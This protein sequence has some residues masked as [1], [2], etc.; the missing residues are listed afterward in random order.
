MRSRTLILALLL[1]ACTA[2][3]TPRPDAPRAA[4]DDGPAPAP[5]LPAS[6]G[7]VAT[8]TIGGGND[9]LHAASRT[10]TWI[11]VCRGEAG[12]LIA[13]ESYSLGFDAW[14]GADDIGR[15]VLVYAG[16][17]P[18]LVDVWTHTA[19]DLP[20][21]GHT[22]SADGRR[23]AYKKDRHTA[24]VR[25][26]ATGAERRFTA[27]EPLSYLVLDPAAAF[28]YMHTFV[29]VQERPDDDAPYV[30][31]STC[32]RPRGE[33]VEG[34]MGRPSATIVALDE[35]GAPQLPLPPRHAPEHATF[36]GRPLVRDDVTGSTLVW[37]ETNLVPLGGD[38]R[39][40]LAAAAR[41]DGLAYVAT[42]DGTPTLMS[43]L[44]G[45][46]R[47]V[48]PAEQ[49]TRNNPAPDSHLTDGQNGVAQATERR[50]L[51]LGT[52]RL[53]TAGPD[54]RHAYADADRMLLIGDAYTIVDP[55]TGATLHRHALSADPGLASGRWI[56]LH[57][58]GETTVLDLDNPA[59]VGHAPGTALALATTGHVLISVAPSSTYTHS[60]QKPYGPYR[61]HAP[62]P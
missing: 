24:V 18:Q 44:A 41:A 29:P 60:K 39:R 43:V 9:T 33:S 49:D 59:W 8:G 14:I 22:L 62:A 47:P 28:L 13:D 54:V 4:P 56:A 58:R 21:T 20:G 6:A 34:R 19:V 7:V 55:D 10:A 45:E 17:R 31:D 38:T 11:A 52:G 15:N 37:H 50:W 1:G 27:R 3:G 25:E 40:S 61:W 26:L 35:P 5:Q 57:G 2:D 53:V 16:E 30:P 42:I 23:L 32:K 48:A 51:H 46:V 36:A 12:L